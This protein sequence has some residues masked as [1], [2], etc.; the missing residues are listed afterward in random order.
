MNGNL[1]ISR[2][3]SNT[4]HT[5]RIRIEDDSSGIVFLET[6]VSLENFALALTSLGY[7]DCEYEL[8][9]LDNIGKKLET[10]TEI[11]PLDNPYRATDEA[12]ELA[13]KPFEIDGW[14]A[15]QSDIKNHHRYNEDTVSVTFSRFV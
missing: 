10:K 9:G 3:T 2:T 6:E 11:V 12:R 1:T 15:R 5:I 7:V 4:G 13:L 14:K 8:Y